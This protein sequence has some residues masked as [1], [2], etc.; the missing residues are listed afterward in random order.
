LKCLKKYQITENNLTLIYCLLAE[1]GWSNKINSLF[2]MGRNQQHFAASFD[3]TVW[4]FTHTNS[5]SLQESLHS[6]TQH[7]EHVD[8]TRHQIIATVPIFL[9]GRFP[10]SFPQ[11]GQED[12]LPLSLLPP[13]M[14]IVCGCCCGGGGGG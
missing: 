13:V 10:V 12:P 14:M 2:K 9:R 6:G 5:V 3:L 7:R 1:T 8:S 4:H 11:A